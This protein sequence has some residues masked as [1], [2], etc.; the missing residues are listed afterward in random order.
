MKKIACLLISVSSLLGCSNHSEV[1][2]ERVQFHS[3]YTSIYYLPQAISTPI[4]SED[5][6]SEIHVLDIDTNRL[7]EIRGTYR[8]ARPKVTVNYSITPIDRAKYRVV[9]DGT[10]NYLTSV[11]IRNYNGNMTINGDSTRNVNIP[12]QVAEVLYGKNIEFTLDDSIKLNLSV[13]KNK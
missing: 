10:I 6:F 12:T 2:N 11:N 8:A 4:Y 5:K 9:L 7:D 3:E 1:H 13:E